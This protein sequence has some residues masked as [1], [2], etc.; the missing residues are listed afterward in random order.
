MTTRRRLFLFGLLVALLVVGAGVWLLWPRTAIT[1]EN[2]A[3]IEVGMTLGEVEAIL[4]GPP[5]NDVGRKL[6][7]DFDSDPIENERLA[8]VMEEEAFA[9]EPFDRDLLQ[10][11]S[12]E[13]VFMA[14]FDNGKVT[15]RAAF[16]AR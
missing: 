12:R 11:R 7:P 3:K 8:G 4:G 5:R 9:T 15:A 1:R 13:V 10:W 2:A 14:V 6:E 16:P